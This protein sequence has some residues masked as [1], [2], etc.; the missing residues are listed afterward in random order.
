MRHY[1]S[2]RVISVVVCLA[3]LVTP[4]FAHS[5]GAADENARS[6][7]S[8]QSGPYAVANGAINVRSGPGT[9]FYITGVLYAG[10][11]VPI[12]GKSADGAWWYIKATFGEGWVA[13]ISVQAYMAEGVAVRDPGPIATVTTGALTVRGGPGP[14][15]A[16]LGYL[17]Q[18]QQVLVVAQ[19][20]GGTWLQ[21][22]WEYGTG[23]ISSAFVSLV[24]TPGMASDIPVTDDS[25]YGIV[26]VAYVN[27][28]SGPGINYEVLG[29]AAGGI[30]LPI[31]GRSADSRW[32][33]VRSAFGT[34]WVYGELVVTRN[35]FG[36]APVQ[37]ANPSATLVGPV[38]VINTG[39]LNI[40][41]GP[42][43]QY[44]VIGTLAGGEEAQIIGRTNDWTW[45]LLETRVGNGW[46]NSIYIIER[47]DLSGVPYVAPGTLTA[48]GQEPSEGVAP[49]PVVAG[50]VAIV[51]TGALHIRSGPNSSFDSLGSVPFGTRMPI[52]G[53]SADRGWW[54]VE[55]VY[56]TGWVT[57]L[58]I[59]VDG[60]TSGVPVR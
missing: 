38:A 23:W 27:I 42:G 40:R 20:A 1:G 10:T 19:N 35:E 8:A 3:V 46:A 7:A 29:Q 51:N 57:K 60:N 25:P 30:Q 32:Y 54:Q 9:G 36:A 4:M 44:T 17:S 13:T 45:W 41:S 59:L 16:S 48:P 31:L 33:Q 49:A 15:A 18:G 2:R 58:L 43:A 50:P 12:L 24:G 6:Q 22:R 56:G 55:S 39:A 34:G 26:L 47:G 28:R 37:P 11:T 21:I 14:T 53:Q 52:V 5:V